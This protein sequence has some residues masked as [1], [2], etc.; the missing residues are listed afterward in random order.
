MMRYILILQLIIIVNYPE[1]PLHP[2]CTHSVILS[3]IL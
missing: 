2:Q 3:Y 1:H